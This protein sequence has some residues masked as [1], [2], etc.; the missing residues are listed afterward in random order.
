MELDDILIGYDR[1]TELLCCIRP[2]RKGVGLQSKEFGKGVGTH[3][4]EVDV[5][6]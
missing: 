2:R 3:H 1:Y 6:T 4:G 5:V